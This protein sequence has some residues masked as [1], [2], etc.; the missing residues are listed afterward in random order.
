MVDVSVLPK[1]SADAH[2]NEPH[3]LWFTRLAEELRDAAPHRIQTEEDGGWRLV[4][5]GAL[6]ESGGS[7]RSADGLSE[8]HSTAGAA[9]R[10]AL[11]EEDRQREADAAVDVRLT[12]M[13]TDGLNAEM[14]YPTIGLYVYGVDR[15][16]V[17]IASCR[18]YNDWI[19]ERLGDDCARIRYAALIP[20]WDVAT[21][22]T[23]V[24]RVAQWRGVGAAMLPLVGTLSW[25]MPEWEPLWSAISEAGVPVVMHQGTGHSMIFFRGWGSP[26]ANLLATQSMASWTSALLSCGGV[27]ERHPDLHFVLVEVNAGW[28]AWTMSTLDEYFLAH[29]AQARKPHLPEL[30]SHY[31]RRQVHATFQRDPIA[32]ACREFTGVEC[33]LW[34]NDFPHAEGTFPH[35]AKVLEDLLTGVD[36]LQAAR[37]TGQNALEIFGFDRVVLTP[38]T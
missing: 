1:I 7:Q 29:Q 14:V 21:A 26:T 15:S 17:G 3:D 36:P 32:V 22:I 24:E 37:I 34:G 9:M 30:P 33:L 25:K 27:L 35:S 28:M 16:D 38:I 8:G 2:V 11:A 20:T 10:A 23:E 5:N 31:L 6:D 18:V 19:H 4:V 12:M 13:R